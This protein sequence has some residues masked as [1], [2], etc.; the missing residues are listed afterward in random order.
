DLLHKSKIR[1]NPTPPK[2]RFV[3]PPRKRGGVGG[4]V[5]GTFAR[6]LGFLSQFWMFYIIWKSL[7]PQHPTLILPDALGR[8]LDFPVSHLCK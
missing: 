5:L 2:L 1:K 8:E 7:A 3:S 6:G 4:G